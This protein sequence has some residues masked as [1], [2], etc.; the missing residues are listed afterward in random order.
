MCDINPI[1][2]IITPCYNGEQYIEDTIKS[3]I[4][5]DF[6]DFEM[7]I[8]DD[9]SSD[10]S[11][12]IIKQYSTKDQRIKYFKT[13]KKSGSPS[14]PRNIGIE[15]SRGKYIAFLDA[16]DIWLPKKLDSQVRFMEDNNL[17]MSYSFYEKIDWNGVRDNRIVK[18]RIVATYKS[19]LISNSI[20]CL[21]SMIRKSVIGDTRFKHIQQED[22]CFWLDILNKGVQAHNLCEVTALYREAKN[23]R[24]A[25]KLDMFKGHWNV[26]RNHQNIGFLQACYY[27]ITYAISGFSKYIK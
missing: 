12:R 6:P 14:L 10:G 16:D 23:S 24:S 2:S 20:P 27:M 11:A 25:N 9:C 19:L 8:I 13:S 15:N 1:V 26:I 5:Q 3:V 4:S 17:D 7:L 22:Y 18:T 21:T